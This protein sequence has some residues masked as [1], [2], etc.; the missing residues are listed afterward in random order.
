MKRTLKIR[1]EVTNG[2]YCVEYRDYYLIHRRWSNSWWDDNHFY[3]CKD[4]SRSSK[5]IYGWNEKQEGP[6]ESL[7][8]AKSCLKRL[9]EELREWE[10]N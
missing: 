4:C 7:L 2:G 1:I 5:L 9:S 10:D 3:C 8:E 6:F